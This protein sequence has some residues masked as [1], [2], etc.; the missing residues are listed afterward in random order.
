MPAVDARVI[1]L[2]QLPERDQ[3]LDARMLRQV[4]GCENRNAPV[5]TVLKVP[6]KDVNPG[7]RIISI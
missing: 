6:E 4:P 5:V 2:V 1:V 7:R 3:L